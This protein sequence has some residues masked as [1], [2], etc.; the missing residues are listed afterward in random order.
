MSTT[1]IFSFVMIISNVPLRSYHFPNFRHGPS[2][3]NCFHRQHSHCNLSSKKTASHK[4]ITSRKQGMDNRLYS[5]WSKCSSKPTDQKHDKNRN[6]SDVLSITW[7]NCGLSEITTEGRKQLA[8]RLKS[9]ILTLDTESHNPYITVLFPPPCPDPAVSRS[10]DR[11]RRVA[12]VGSRALEFGQ[13][14]YP[15]PN[16]SH[17][18]HRF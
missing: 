2:K 1:G 5:L 15:P 13:N 12:R 9:V 17:T 7:S 4:S 6:S 16:S 8:R 11:I 14:R 10:L 18:I 3:W